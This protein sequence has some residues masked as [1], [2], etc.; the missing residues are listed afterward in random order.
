MSLTCTV[1]D[2]QRVTGRKSLILTTPHVLGTFVVRDPTG[3]LLRSWAIM[4][5]PTFSRFGRTLTSDRRTDRQT[6]GNNIYQAS[7]ASGGKTLT[8]RI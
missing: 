4:R 5:D 1:S 6:Q 3:I 7:V 2:M 8:T